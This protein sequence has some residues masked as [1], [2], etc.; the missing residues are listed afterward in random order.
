MIE[1]AKNSV[2]VRKGKDGKLRPRLQVGDRRQ[3]DISE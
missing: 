3:N 2:A 1:E